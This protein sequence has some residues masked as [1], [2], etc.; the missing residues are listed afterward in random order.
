MDSALCL[1]VLEGHTGRIWDI[2]SNKSGNIIA[3]ASGDET[4]RLWDLRHLMEVSEKALVEQVL[5]E[6]EEDYAQ[7]DGAEFGT[8]GFFNMS[9]GGANSSLAASGNSEEKQQDAIDEL[10]EKARESLIMAKL[11]KTGSGHRRVSGKKTVWKYKSDAASSLDS[12]FITTPMSALNPPNL[13][14]H[15]S[16]YTHSNVS[17]IKIPCIATLGGRAETTGSVNRY[18]TG[19]SMGNASSGSGTSTPTNSAFPGLYQN[20]GYRYGL[21]GLASSSMAGLGG[22]GGSGNSGDP[23]FGRSTFSA[24][25]HGGDVYSV[26]WHPGGS[27]IVTGGYDKIVRLFD[28]T[29]EQIIK[30]FTGHQLSVSKVIF[31]PLGNLI[32][33]GSKDSTIKFWDI[34]SG[35]CIKTITSHLG[36]VTNVEVNSNGTLLLSSSKDNSNRLWDIRMLRP[37]RKFRGHQNTSKNFVR[38]GFAGDSIIVGGSEVCSFIFNSH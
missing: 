12:S 31:N 21:G 16:N 24:M 26:R 1:S 6:E 37:I 34:V 30:T 23:G 11:R 17:H 25:G 2:A 13:Q 18:V 36:E 22:I 28:V 38:A 10:G 8:S 32:I 29:T 33:S 14:Q 35:V 3:S 5:I 7:G 4:V 19:I 20:N 15:S 27:H 9:A